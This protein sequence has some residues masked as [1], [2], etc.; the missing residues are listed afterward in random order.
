M[1]S[2]LW[3]FV[4]V[5][6]LAAVAAAAFVA[7]GRVATGTPA[8]KLAGWVKTTALGEDIGTLQSEGRD[9]ARA[10]A[11]HS[12]TGVVHTICSAMATDAQTYNDSL[13]SPDTAVTQDLARAYSLAYDAAEECYKAGATNRPLFARS[14]ADSARARRLFAAVVRRIE[15]LTRSSVSTTTTTGP[16]TTGT[17]L[18]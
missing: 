12:G 15:R 9:V 14:E 3:I 13:P 1:R 10:A 16:G 8:Q 4:V 5:A 6:L 18:F 11:A 7:D 17:A 2:R